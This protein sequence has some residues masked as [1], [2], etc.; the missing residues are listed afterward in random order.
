MENEICQHEKYAIV[1]Q[2]RNA[3]IG[4]CRRCGLVF[5]AEKDFAESDKN[6]Q[7]YYAGETASR[8]GKKTEVVVKFFRFLR[9]IKMFFL[10]YGA[11]S[12]LDIGSGR[13]WM[14]YFLKKYFRYKVAIGTQIS[15]AAYNF[16]KDKLKLEIYH[17]DLLAIKWH[18]NFDLITLWHVLEHVES[19]EA[20]L[21]KIRELLKKNG[22]LVVEVPNYDSW[23][24]VLTKEYW[25][26]LDLKHHRTFFTPETLELLLKKYNFK[27]KRLRT[28]SLEYSA[29]TSAQSL[30][31]F[32][33]RTDDYFFR[34][35]QDGGFSL[36]AMAHIL[37]FSVLLPACLFIN[38][39][40]YF[41]RQG[42]VIN[43]IAQKNDE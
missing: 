31:N 14:L 43:V 29:F 42:E 22:H 21:Q 19:P 16:S 10:Q 18:K 41:S 6:Y 25:L 17:Q 15:D 13:G 5:V 9:A 7:N 27:I 32:L 33:T 35:L 20:Y 38:L 26:A 36:K 40:L 24:S 2:A 23:T 12:I 1:S 37:L 34:W 28:F 11:D 30:V 4:K 3:K 8:F 39:L